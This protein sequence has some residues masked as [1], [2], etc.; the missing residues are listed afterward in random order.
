M[1][2]T[3]PYLKPHVRAIASRV[4]IAVAR[5]KHTKALLAK[6]RAEALRVV[7]RTRMGH[8]FLFAHH[9]VRT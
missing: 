1:P 5:R 3:L 4:R 2:R 8:R 7:E 6:A 9:H